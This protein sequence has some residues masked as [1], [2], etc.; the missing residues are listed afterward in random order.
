MKR[1]VINTIEDLEMFI[2]DYFDDLT[3]KQIE[4][5]WQ[6]LICEV[7]FIDT[8]ITKKDLINFINH[9][10]NDIENGIIECPIFIIKD[11]FFSP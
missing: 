6:D 7:S 1:I 11:N 4:S 3:I 5:I 8:D 10:G 2:N 9:Y